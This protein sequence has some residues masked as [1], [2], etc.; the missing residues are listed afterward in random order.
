MTSKLVISWQL[1]AGNPF[2]ENV[3][4]PNYLMFTIPVIAYYCIS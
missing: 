1:Q 4:I 3:T 2:F